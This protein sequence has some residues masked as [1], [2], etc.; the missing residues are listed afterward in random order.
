MVVA[1]T[2][3]FLLQ[4]QTSRP[5][6]LPWHGKF[7]GR[8]WRLIT[9]RISVNAHKVSASWWVGSQIFHALVC[10]FCLFLC[11]PL[12]A[13]RPT[14]PCLRRRLIS[15]PLSLHFP[16]T[17]FPS[18]FSFCASVP[19]VSTPPGM[20]L[21]PKT[22]RRA[23]ARA[24]GEGGGGPSGG[25]EIPLGNPQF[26]STWEDSGESHGFRVRGPGYLSGGGKVDA[27]TPFGKLV[28]A[29]LFKVCVVFLFWS[30]FVLFVCFLGCLFS[31]FFVGPS[32]LLR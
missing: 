30:K 24:G 18:V 19:K 27:G 20:A 3:S 21:S 2:D 16:S 32:V 29:D 10:S 22:R 31:F 12:I 23:A 13:G 15:A 11:C 9:L 7:S 8:R 6:C 17:P 28:R 14:Y 1:G 5:L 4:G 25:E 26:Q